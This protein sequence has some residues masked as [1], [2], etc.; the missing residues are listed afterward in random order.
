MVINMINSLVKVTI[1]L[2][3]LKENNQD[4]VTTILDCESLH[5]NINTFDIRE[6]LVT[7]LMCSSPL[8]GVHLH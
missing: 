6:A 4:N 3:I 5:A 2:F 1:I 7:S 8:K